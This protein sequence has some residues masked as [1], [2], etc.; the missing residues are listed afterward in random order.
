M[1]ATLP[2]ALYLLDYFGIAVFAVSGALLAAMVRVTPGE[3]RGHH[4]FGPADPEASAAMGLTSM[5]SMDEFIAVN[6]VNYHAYREGL[7]G[8]PGVTLVG[9]DPREKSSYQYVITE[10]DEALKH[11][12]GSRLGDSR[13]WRMLRSNVNRGA[14]HDKLA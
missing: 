6:L 1:T 7:A 10:I 2:D 14:G 12:Q 9:Y 11:S 4:T 8:I 13:Q 3:V 5:E